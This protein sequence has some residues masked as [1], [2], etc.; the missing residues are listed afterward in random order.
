MEEKEMGFFKKMVKAITDFD[1]YAKLAPPKVGKSIS[2]LIKLIALFAIVIS[3]GITYKFYHTANQTFEYFKQDL[4]NFTSQNNELKFES[5]EPIVLRNEE[6]MPATVIIDTNAQTEEEVEKDKKDMEAYENGILFLK[7]KIIMKTAGQTGYSVYQ[8]KELSEKYQIGDFNKAQAVEYISNSG[9]TQILGAV[10][11]MMVFY[12]FIIYIVSTLFDAL[13]LSMLG[14]LTTRMLG[15]RLRYGAIYN[16]AVYAL[17][18]PIILNAIY[19]NVNALTGFTIKYFQIMYNLVSYIY[20]ITVIFIIRSGMIKQKMEVM[21]LVEEQ[22]K[23]KE[24][25]QNRKGEKKEIPEEKPKEEAKKEEKDTNNK[26]E[27]EGS[28]A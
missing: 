3:I 4:P 28:E 9:M 7:D 8:Y 10:Y 27:P 1:Y 26:E 16:I 21:K 6:I 15:I 22:K 5:Q 24:E 11:L 12:M 17:T 13:I 14:Y 18:L 2:Y 20:M 19:I 23:L 25:M